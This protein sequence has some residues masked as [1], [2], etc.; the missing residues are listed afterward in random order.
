MTV[1]T[2]PFNKHTFCFC[3]IKVVMQC[4][5]L[6]SFKKKKKISGFNKY[7]E[8]RKSLFLERVAL[9]NG[10]QLIVKQIVDDV[11]YMIVFYFRTM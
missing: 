4:V 10:W 8:N 7:L 5:L 1:I 3:T 9:L 11:I 6:L 2:T